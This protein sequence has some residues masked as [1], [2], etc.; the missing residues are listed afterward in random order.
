MTDCSGIEPLLAARAFC[1]LE[2]DELQLVD[3]HLERCAACQAAYAGLAGLPGLLDLAG[4]AEA[5]IAVPPALLEASVLGALPRPR[6][7]PR[8]RRGPLIR[9]RRG[10]VLG[11]ALAAV[12]VLA[13]GLAPL[14]RDRKGDQIPGVTLVAAPQEP[15]AR[16]VVQVRRHPWG[17]EVD[18]QAQ[19]LAPSRGT[20]IYEVWFV[21]PR[22]RVS[23]GTFTVGDQGRVTVRLAS[24]ARSGQYDSIGITREPDGLNPARRGPNVFRAPLPA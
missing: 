3:A 11:A 4:S 21:S 12:L 24:A 18:L 6:E 23:A 15:G 19:D 10:P 17:T 7:R 2:P 8:P 5:L 1:A 16:A 9:R 22:G 20:Q 14:L 13:L